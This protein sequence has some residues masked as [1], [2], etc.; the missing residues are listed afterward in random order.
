MDIWTT[1]SGDRSYLGIV[2]NWV[3]S[4][5]NI[6]N[7]L[8]A[9]PPIEGQH[10][11]ANIAATA[12][13]V[14][15]EYGFGSKVG[16]CMLD[17]VSNNDT[18][19]SELQVLLVERYG[20]AI[21]SISAEERRLHCFGHNLN[22]GARE[23][24]YGKESEAFEFEGIDPQNEKAEEEEFNLW[25]KMDSIGKA[26]NFI[27][28]L[29]RS[30][31]HRDVFR[32]IQTDILHL[33]RSILPSRDNRTRWNTVFLMMNDMLNLHKTIEL[34]ISLSLNSKTMEKKHKQQLEKHCT[35]TDEDWEELIHIHAILYDFWELTMRMQGNVVKKV[36]ESF[37]NPAN[38]YGNPD[39]QLFDG[40]PINPISISSS[41]NED[42]ALFNVLPAFEHI[43]SKLEAAKNHAI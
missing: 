34:Y 22:L 33:P 1:P 36:Q 8:I 3:D 5:F 14:I 16:Y 40:T 30:N 19:M 20:A 27:V 17:G 28:F 37:T 13:R 38:M 39:A 2:A 31:Q 29:Y 11:G 25:R 24:M 26:H 9:L 15:E 35:L 12:F 41:D 18:G 7:V 21:I 6:R 4:D 10:T 43:L 42:D 23:A 32:E